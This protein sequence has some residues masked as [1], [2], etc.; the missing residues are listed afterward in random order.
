MEPSPNSTLSCLSNTAKPQRRIDFMDLP[1]DIRH[2]IYL[3]VFGHR[4]I[5]IHDKTYLDWRGVALVDYKLTYQMCSSQI[6]E[7]ELYEVYSTPVAFKNAMDRHLRPREEPPAYHW[8]HQACYDHLHSGMGA[9]NANLLLLLL[10]QYV[11]S[12]FRIEGRKIFYSTTTFSFA[13]PRTITKW[14][15]TVPQDMRHR[16]KNIHLDID[17]DWYTSFRIPGVASGNMQWAKVTACIIPRDFPNTETLH[18]S[19]DF[20]AIAACWRLS[21]AGFLRDMV[22]PLQGLKKLG[23]LTVVINE[24]YN[25]DCRLRLHGASHDKD[26]KTNYFHRKAIRRIWAEEIRDMFLQKGS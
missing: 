26:H 24:R 5:H 18:L 9:A 21:H 25:P 4:L 6:S 20:N 10:P 23:N 16:T 2:L 22:R 12:E 11:S 7:D 15:A 13:Q 14:L 19:F 3:K 8:P 17:M 1:F